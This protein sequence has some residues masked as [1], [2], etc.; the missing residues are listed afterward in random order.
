MAFDRS[1]WN[2]L[3]KRNTYK[4]TVLPPD[5]QELLNSLLFTMHPI[6]MYLAELFLF[7]ILSSCD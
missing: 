3:P 7:S 4:A 5:K 2:F 1:Q 6:E